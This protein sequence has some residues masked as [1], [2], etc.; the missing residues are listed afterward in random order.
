[1]PVVIEDKY[2]EIKTSSIPNAGLGLFTTI[3]IHKDAYIVEYTGI[4]S[5]WD[6]A[7]HQNG[8]NLYLFYITEDH[9]IDGS[10]SK[11]CK[12]RYANDARGLTR[13]EK[14]RNNSTFIEDD[15]RIFIQATRNIRAGSEILVNY[16]PDYWKTIR[17]NIEIDKRNTH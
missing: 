16:G 10:K 13:V 1:M 6:D 17:K 14:L 15:K 8:D 11:D 5:S 9:V 4:I 7:D 12:A 2:I 3:D